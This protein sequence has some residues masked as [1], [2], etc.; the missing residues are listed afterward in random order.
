MKT[1]RDLKQDGVE[2]CQEH[3][4]RRIKADLLV[5][6]T[7]ERIAWDAIQLRQTFDQSLVV[8]RRIGTFEVILDS[9]GRMAG[10][11]DHDKYATSKEGAL[12]PD[13]ADALVA[14][15]GMVP[16]GAKRTDLKERLLPAGPRFYRGRYELRYPLPDYDAVD[17]D[18]NPTRKEIIAIRP[19]PRKT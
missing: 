15:L 14:A 11:V 13:E 6:S 10:F 12:T 17:V 8:W 4:V 16:V 2:F 7:T 9:L 18:F 19:L 1:L 3:A 5:E